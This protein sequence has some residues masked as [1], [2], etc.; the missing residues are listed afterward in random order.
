MIT[1]NI[2]LPVR[3]VVLCVELSISS[4]KREDNS[5][6]WDVHRHLGWACTS[7]TQNSPSQF[8]E[9]RPFLTTHMHVLYIWNVRTEAFPTVLC[10]KLLR[11]SCFAWVETLLPFQTFA[12]LRALKAAQ[13]SALSPAPLFFRSKNKTQEAVKTAPRW[14]GCQ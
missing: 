10:E 14:K 8:T 13:F 4:W 7:H 1:L 3:H 12:V 5:P 9:C 2:G 6:H 11:C